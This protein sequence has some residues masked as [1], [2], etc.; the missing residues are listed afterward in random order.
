MY[1]SKLA[2]DPSYASVMLDVADMSGMHKRLMRAFP[3]RE[4]DEARRSMEILFRMEVGRGN[5]AV[6][7]Q[8]SIEPDWSLLEGRT[9]LHPP[10]VKNIE[11]AIESIG[12]GQALRFRVRANPVRRVKADGKK[13][14]RKVGLV[15]E[16]EQLDWLRRRGE[17]W[18][19]DV[20]DVRAIK[21][22]LARTKDGKAFESVLFDGVLIVRDRAQFI[23][24][25]RA[26]IGSGKAYGFG[27]FS[28]APGVC[29]T[30]GG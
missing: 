16:E 8:S 12:T 4:G 24:C 20:S 26:G 6:F 7:V 3:D 10:Q 14:G 15:K 13:N 28:L 18:G 9:F 21:E 17:Q 5:I 25:V 22:G 11:R 19:F 29:I 1:L 30:G 23:E 27:M 2:L